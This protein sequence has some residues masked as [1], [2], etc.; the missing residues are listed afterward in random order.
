MKQNSSKSTHAIKSFLMRN[1]LASGAV[2]YTNGIKVDLQRFRNTE[3][4]WDAVAKV[5]SVEYPGEDTDLL[6]VAESENQPHIDKIL[7]DANKLPIVRADVRMM[8]FRAN[9]PGQLEL[10]F[11]KLRWTIPAPPQDRHRRR[12]SACRHGDADPPLPRAAADD[13]VRGFQ[14]RSVARVLG[15]KPTQPTSTSSQNPMR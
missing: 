13:P 1:G 7:E 14:R 10:H 11:D 15:S 4:M 2:G 5:P 8:F 3:F 9:D 6:F 12:L